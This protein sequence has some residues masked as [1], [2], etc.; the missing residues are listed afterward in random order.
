MDHIGSLPGDFYTCNFLW[1]Y[2]VFAEAGDKVFVVNT[3]DMILYGLH[4]QTKVW[5]VPQKVDTIHAVQYAAMAFCSGRLYITGGETIG[6]KS[7]EKSMISLNVDK[8]GKSSVSAQT[9]PDMKYRRSEHSMVCVD[10]KVVVC[11][12]MDDSVPLATCEVFDPVTAHWSYL[13]DLPK[14][15]W[16]VGLI[17]TDTAMFVAGGATQYFGDD[18]PL[19]LS[20]TVAMYNWQTGKWIIL[21]HLPFPLAYVHAVYRGGSLWVLGAISRS[22]YATHCSQSTEYILEYSITEE[23]WIKHF[24]HPGNWI[25]DPVS[26]FIFKI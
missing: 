11:G 16:A 8:E 9:E 13:T 12:G 4:V 10:G 17:H 18:H 20:D 6:G 15:G 25:I 22:G 5:E 26:A 23:I 21:P 14:A 3:K 1:L 24:K 7:T 2:R 19:I